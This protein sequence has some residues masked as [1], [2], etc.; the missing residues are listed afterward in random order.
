M[1]KAVAPCPRRW[2]AD[3]QSVRLN[4]EE[5]LNARQAGQAVLAQLAEANAGRPGASDRRPRLT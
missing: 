2:E 5:G 4:L 1:D 3:A